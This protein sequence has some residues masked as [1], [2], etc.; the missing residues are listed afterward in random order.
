MPTVTFTPASPIVAATL[1]QPGGDSYTAVAFSPVQP[2]IIVI[3]VTPS[4][5]ATTHTD[6][7]P[8]FVPA[9]LRVPHARVI[10]PSGNAF[11]EPSGDPTNYK[12]DYR[13]HSMVCVDLAR[14]GLFTTLGLK[15][16]DAAVD[17]R[18]VAYVFIGYPGMNPVVAP[19]RR[20]A[21]WLDWGHGLFLTE[22]FAELVSYG[23]MSYCR[24]HVIATDGIGGFSNGWQYVPYVKYAPTY[25]IFTSDPREYFSQGN[26]T[27]K[28]RTETSGITIDG[29][30]YPAIGSYYSAASGVTQWPYMV[31]PV[32]PATLAF[33]NT[34]M[35]ED[36]PVTGGYIYVKQGMD[37][38][39]QTPILP[40]TQKT[41][42]R[43]QDF[44][45][46][47]EYLYGTLA[48]W[49]T[50]PSPGF[51]SQEGRFL[52]AE[53]QRLVQGNDIQSS[54]GYFGWDTPP[55]ETEVGVHGAHWIHYRNNGVLGRG[56]LGGAY[57]FHKDGLLHVIGGTLAQTSW[58]SADGLGYLIGRMDS[59]TRASYDIPSPESMSVFSTPTGYYAN[60][61]S[62][63][64][65]PIIPPNGGTWNGVLNTAILN[66]YFQQFPDCP[67]PMD[68]RGQSDTLIMRMLGRPPCMGV[69]F[70]HPMT[71]AKYNE[72][73][74]SP[75]FPFPEVS[76]WDDR[77]SPTLFDTVQTPVRERLSPYYYKFSYPNG[78]LVARDFLQK[79]GAF[80]S[81]AATNRLNRISAERE[82]VF[83]C[84]G[85]LV[86][87]SD[88]TVYIVGG[89]KSSN[90][91]YYF[92]TEVDWYRMQRIITSGETYASFAATGDNSWYMVSEYTSPN[93][94]VI[95][96]PGPQVSNKVYKINDDLVSADPTDIPENRLPPG[97][98]PVT[99]DIL[100]HTGTMVNGRY[101]HAVVSLG[102]DRVAIIGGYTAMPTSLWQSIN[103]KPTTSIE[104]LDL[105]T[106]VS[107][108]AGRLK[109]PR[110]YHSVTE[111]APKAF[112][113]I[114]GDVRHRWA[115]P[116]ISTAT[117]YTYQNPSPPPTYEVLNIKDN[118]DMR[119]V[120]Y[121]YLPNAGQNVLTVQN[122]RGHSAI[123]DTSR[124]CVWTMGGWSSN[125]L[126]VYYKSPIPGSE[127]R[128]EIEIPD[129][130]FPLNMGSKMCV[131]GI[132][133]PPGFSI[134]YG[135]VDVPSSIFGTLAGQN[136]MY[137]Q[138]DLVTAI[139]AAIVEDRTIEPGLWLAPYGYTDSYGIYGLFDIP[140]GLKARHISDP[141]YIYRINIGRLL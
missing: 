25:S 103:M 8:T 121:G 20:Q 48:T 122:L 104:I 47:S 42:M 114:G 124:N 63:I 10:Y 88:G 61:L 120:S 7:T 33:W 14:D 140:V 30:F 115:S 123:V 5:D 65:M 131:P 15:A 74:N 24:S 51:Y 12:P 100:E 84:D 127:T 56:I 128:F 64:N 55:T 83:P 36:T 138:A 113:V 109:V 68:I 85:E 79:A 34:Y 75:V 45:S 11:R 99:K 54:Q 39:F 13:A 19:T 86:K 134:T 43:A 18:G 28:Q 21:A 60:V 137:T 98:G 136:S 105:K 2:F 3:G 110:A 67:H 102:Q 29:V 17:E 107:A 96:T 35:Y 87:G 106:G 126:I 77:D 27:E 93:P 57:V 49:D 125:S 135:Q 1:P 73:R 22:D 58:Q 90:R 129:L 133:Q 50:I 81:S 71:L 111:I 9:Y 132:D 112:L 59:T 66:A 26:N 92:N 23:G 80:D 94:Y 52:Q 70:A 141:A 76:I 108:P 16:I 53:L 91:S 117:V 31:T 78:Q 6:A 46:I 37:H 116:D 139:N 118:G 40:T 38:T 62:T 69:G 4:G 119:T 41:L 82:I 89:Y 97:P 32:N 130:P 72:T 101:G 44:G 95:G